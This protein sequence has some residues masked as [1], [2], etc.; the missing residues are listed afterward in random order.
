[1]ENRFGVKDFVLMLLLVVL[2]VSVWLGMKQYD[3]QWEAVRGIE[4][5]LKDIQRTL[6]R[7]VAVNTGGGGTSVGSAS[8]PV[9]DSNDPFKRMREAR[10]NPDYA[11]GDWLVEATPGGIA[12]LTPFL[13]GDKYA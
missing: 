10:A 3:R 8:R 2:I 11:Q 12:K 4:Q 13:A 7:G 9:I 5:S 6:A 1:M